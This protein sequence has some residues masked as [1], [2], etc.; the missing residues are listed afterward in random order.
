MGLVADVK[1][2]IEQQK[3]KL[4]IRT[5]IAQLLSR[6]IQQCPESDQYKITNIAI[7]KHILSIQDLYKR[8]F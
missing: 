6:M 2:I 5:Q 7:E 8:N 1:Y 4:Y 3:L